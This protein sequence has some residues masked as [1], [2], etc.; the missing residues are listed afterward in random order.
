MRNSAYI[1]FNPRPTGFDTARG[2]LAFWTG[3]SFN[4]TLTEKLRITNSG[5]V[6]IGVTD[7]KE[8]LQIATISS[9]TSAPLVLHNG[10][11]A[12]I[13]HNWFYTNTDQIFESTKASTTISLSQ[14]RFI[15]R[16]R[17]ANAAATA[18]TDTLFATGENGGRVGIKNSNPSTTLDVNGE[19]LGL[20]VS[21][22]NKIQAKIYSFSNEVPFN[23]FNNTILGP[24]TN[25]I[26][27]SFQNSLV[28]N[29]TLF[30]KVGGTNSIS[31]DGNLINLTHNSNVSGDLNVNGDLTVDGS[32]GNFE[33]T[34][35][36]RITNNEQSTN[37][38]IYF[39]SIG[40]QTYDP[41]TQTGGF[42]ILYLPS[43]LSNQYFTASV[44]AYRVGALVNLDIECTT[45][46]NFNFGY[47][48]FYGIQFYLQDPSSRFIP[49]SSFY[50]SGMGYTMSY[51]PLVV[52]A[53]QID[54]SG[55]GASNLNRDDIFIVRLR[56]LQTNNPTIGSEFVTV[57]S[58]KAGTKFFG[59]I[60]YKA[61]N[62]VPPTPAPPPVTPAVVPAFLTGLGFVQ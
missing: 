8:F 18:Y 26:F 10:G 38:S 57:T 50:G 31:T 40:G 5:K 45:L 48:N 30:L 32:Y 4:N 46:S 29:P 44:S 42:N 9:S 52:E 53:F 13:G 43:F 3:L 34:N 16:N 21:S 47:S 24:G 28:T 58:L 56:T 51:Y 6:G 2:G 35:N 1:A 25:A 27:T 11:S 23:L 22:N 37:L 59:T 19:I 20:T 15:V 36:G 39:S 7:P 14:G 17:V 12:V 61:K 33:V 41:N 55:G 62:I 60:S 54:P 49:S